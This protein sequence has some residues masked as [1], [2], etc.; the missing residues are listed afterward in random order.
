[1]NSMFVFFA[2]GAFDHQNSFMT[3]MYVTIPWLW[4]S[5]SNTP[6]TAAVLVNHEFWG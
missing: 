2:E 4:R 6:T 3:L 1:M 5:K